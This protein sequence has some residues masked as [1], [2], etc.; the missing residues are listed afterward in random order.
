MFYNILL[1]AESLQLEENALRNAIVQYGLKVVFMGIVIFCAV[2]LGMFL[3]K[4]KNNKEK[5]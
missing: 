1:E 3:R 5:G 4:K 2:N